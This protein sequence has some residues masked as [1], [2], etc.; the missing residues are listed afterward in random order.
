M[1]FS[2]KVGFWEEDTEERPGVWRSRIVER[3]Y[4][5]DVLVDYRKLRMGDTQNGSFSVNNK[6]SI[7]GDLYAKENWPSIK[8]VVWNGVKWIV[9]GVK[10]DYPRL[11]LDLGEV[12]NENEI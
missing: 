8:Y 9:S 2:G 10:V 7:L 3:P 12:Y 5:G 1:K 4:T 6:I 11:V